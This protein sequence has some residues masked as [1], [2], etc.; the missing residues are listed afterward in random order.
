[1][2]K[3][4][5]S[6]VLC[7]LIGSGTSFAQNLKVTGTVTSA[8]DGLPVVGAS[9][10]VQGTTNGTITDADGQYNLD[11]VPTGS[12]LIFSCIGMID[13]QRPAAGVVNVVLVSD[14]ELLDEVV[15]TA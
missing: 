13:Q 2:S 10:F 6:L 12:T 5:I 7:L 15:V 14:N 4:F 3:K 9:V 8:E 11:N 1:M